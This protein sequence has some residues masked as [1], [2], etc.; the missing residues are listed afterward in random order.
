MCITNY[1]EDDNDAVLLLER[2]EEG[3]GTPQGIGVQE[4]DG[5]LPQLMP[6]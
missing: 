2:R 3:E 6:E 4:E 5:P 1:S